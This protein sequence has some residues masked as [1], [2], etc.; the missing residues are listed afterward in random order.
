MRISLGFVALETSGSVEGL[1]D[2]FEKF[3]SNQKF[4]WSWRAES[5]RCRLLVGHY[6]NLNGQSFS[7][8]S[9]LSSKIQCI[10][11]WSEV[12]II[13]VPVWNVH[14]LL[15]K[16]FNKT[17]FS[18]NLVFLLLKT[19]NPTSNFISVSFC[20]F[21]PSSQKFHLRMSREYIYFDYACKLHFLDQEISFLG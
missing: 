15:S 12:C 20:R 5:Y 4:P 6:F 3:T 18:L 8:S 16:D 17:W 14:D 10:G 7:E 2:D 21:S 9:R 11:N 13:F 19:E 1:H